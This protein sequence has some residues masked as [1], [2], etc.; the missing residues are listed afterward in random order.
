MTAVSFSINRGQTDSLRQ[1]DLTVGTSVPG[2]GDIELRYQLLDVNGHALTKKNVI[3]ALDTFKLAI[4]SGQL[5]TNA[6]P[7]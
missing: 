1:S 6:P 4:E 2:A 7:L 3:T 5:Y